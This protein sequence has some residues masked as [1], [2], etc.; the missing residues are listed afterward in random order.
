M[1][2]MN[3]AMQYM[4]STPYT[5]A[6]QFLPPVT[7][8]NYQDNVP[9]NDYGDDLNKSDS[10]KVLAKK[11][12]S[13]NFRSDDLDI[14]YNARGK[15]IDKLQQQLADVKAEYEAEL[16]SCRHQ[17]ALVK[18]EHHN[19]A[20]DIDQLRRVVS[21]T[22]RE[23]KVLTDEIHN[24]SV[25]IKI[26]VEENESL[27]IEKESSSN[28]IQQLQIQLSQ[29]QTNDSVLKARNQHE[30][31]VRSIVDRHKE[32]VGSLRL[33]VDKMNTKLV[34]QE[35]EN[36]NLHQKLRHA[37]SEKEEAVKS[38]L[39]T[40]TE[41]NGKLTDLSEKLTEALQS[42]ND[43]EL[44][45]LQAELILEKQEREKERMERQKFEREVN[46][47]KIKI[48]LQGGHKESLISNRTKQEE[49]SRL[50]ASLKT[51]DRELDLVHSN[52]ES[53]MK[54]FHSAAGINAS[55]NLFRN[56]N[57][58]DEFSEISEISASEENES[59]KEKKSHSR[60]ACYLQRIVKEIH[61]LNKE[62]QSVQYF[63]S[64][65]CKISISQDVLN[66]FMYCKI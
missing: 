52:I 19:S 63:V 51:K 43:D 14:L 48:G 15:E 16:R 10:E 20:G 24:L 60:I 62:L 64:D 4:T 34:L 32:E 41:L 49:I 23:N 8:Y 54:V 5:H 38:K 65:N 28:I 33:E 56:S 57:K 53:V 29:L 3:G 27:Q 12:G 61:L 17:L 26:L 1:T 9:V 39:E 40:V 46:Q 44:V 18:S 11:L 45:R 50:E 66:T 37:V 36:T 21:D 55:H 22:K 7:P 58:E 47:L 35:Q 42:T 13:V 30:A 59:E 6:D 31:T 2:P 25:K